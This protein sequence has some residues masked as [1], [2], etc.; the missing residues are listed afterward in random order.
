MSPSVQE[1][2]AA[3]NFCEARLDALQ[4][5]SFEYFRRDTNL[6]NGCAPPVGTL[7]SSGFN[8]APAATG[9]D[10]RMGPA[11]VA[12]NRIAKSETAGWRWHRL[13]AHYL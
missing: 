10:Q 2:A 6:V 8:S 13:Q 12:D 7:A 9:M 11:S 5:H 1:N 3:Q 4:R